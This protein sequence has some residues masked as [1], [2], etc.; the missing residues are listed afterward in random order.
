MPGTADFTHAPVVRGTVIYVV[1][2]I[3]LVVVWVTTCL[4]VYVRAIK[5]KSWGADDWW[6]MLTWASFTAMGISMILLAYSGFGKHIWKVPT[7]WIIFGFKSYLAA[8]LEYI[9]CVMFLK[10]SICAFFLRL[11]NLKWQKWTVW[12][13]IAVN[14]LYSIGY[15]F[16]ILNQCSPISH[17]WDQ[18]ILKKGSCLPESTILG[19][20]Y[21]HNTMSIVSDWILSTLPIFLLRKS[22]LKKQAKVII[23]VLLCLG[24][25]SSVASMIRMSSLPTLNRTLDYTYTVTP[26]AIWSAVEA[27]VG[28]L[29]ANLA[30]FRPLLSSYVQTVT[31]L[32]ST[33]S[34]RGGTSTSRMSGWR[35]GKSQER[36]TLNSEV[37]DMN[38]LQ[39]TDARTVQGSSVS[40]RTSTASGKKNVDEEMGIYKQTELMIREEKII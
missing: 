27:A 8:E 34:R 36:F 14:S 13:V 35:R 25:F 5:I 40:D 9:L 32:D 31:T 4:R 37:H 19:A 17:L 24:Y 29:A 33:D 26:I 16:L 12:V 1:L 30:T 22:K 28:I 2:I 38:R 10:I 21:A 20:S 15:F 7:K 39:S 6:M 11:T 3:S 23:I 18:I